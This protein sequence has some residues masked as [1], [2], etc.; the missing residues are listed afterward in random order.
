[1][2]GKVTGGSLGWIRVVGNKVHVGKRSDVRDA[3]EGVCVSCVVR[4]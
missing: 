1:V 4:W 3:W 2:E